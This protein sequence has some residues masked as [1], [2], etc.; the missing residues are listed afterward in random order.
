MEKKVLKE[1]I[2]IEEIVD[3]IRS[4]GSVGPA[5]HYCER[6]GCSSH[7]LWPRMAA[8]DTDNAYRV[9]SCA[10]LPALCT[11]EGNARKEIEAKT[12]KPVISS[13]NA[14]SMLMGSVVTEMI[15]KL[16]DDK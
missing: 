5:D 2:F 15:E 12:G 7:I 3:I 4:G 11:D 10:V 1:P 6:S 13:E 8:A 9:K 14:E 16:S